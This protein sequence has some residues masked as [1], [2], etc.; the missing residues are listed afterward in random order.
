MAD[1]ELE[2]SDKLF[3]P[4]F[5]HLLP[6]LRDPA[7]RY[8]FIEG[9]SSASK[10]YTIC[11]ALALD[12]LEYEYSVMVF[13]RQQV[14]IKDSVMESFKEAIEGLEIKEF[15]VPLNN[16]IRVK[17]DDNKVRFR[18]LD[19]EE[20]IKGMAKYQVVYNNEWSQFLERHFDQQRKRLRGRPNQKFICDWNPISAKLW[21]YENLI[22]RDEWIDLPL[23][24]QGRKYSSLNSEKSFKRINRKGNTLWIKV[25]Y[26]DNYWIVGHPDGKGGYKDEHTLADYDWDRIH[27]PNL[28]RVY[29]DGERGIIRTGGE[30]WKQ[31][32]ELVHVKPVTVDMAR[33][34]HISIDENVNPY[35]TIAGWQVDMDA[36]QLRQ[37]MELPC[38]S[39]D[40]NAP[41]AAMKLLRWLD[42]VGYNDVIYLYGDPSTQKRSTIDENNRS[43]YDKFIHVL[44]EGGYHIVSRVGRAHPQ[45]AL[46][47]A[48][49]NDIYE[50]LLDW[51]IV[52]G[53]NCKVSIDDYIMVKEA[54]DGTMAKQKVK[55]ENTDTSIEMYGHFSDAK[56]YFI[57]KVL[58][59]EFNQYKAR[60]KRAR[61][62]AAKRVT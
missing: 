60:S 44:Q 33:P 24:I 53:D 2:F 4:L 54:P 16:L 18:G 41:K 34:L 56:R 6:A 36:M 5:W 9:G 30:F 25:T 55:D 43:F 37:V 52:I 59:A 61:S 22:D 49:V 28:Y 50:G 7:I 17:G 14:D 32:N 21:Q 19:K 11:Q 48:F 3:N 57:T 31:F 45:I 35:V 47:A 10:T 39:P 40:N 27:K 1:V 38:R 62:I 13:R 58:E 8:I 23:S 51:S 46:S 26:R 12:M 15:F 20:N 29:A 42:K